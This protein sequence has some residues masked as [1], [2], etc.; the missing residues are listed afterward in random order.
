VIAADQLKDWLTI[1]FAILVGSAALCALLV[2]VLHPL[3]VRYALARPNARSSHKVPVPQGAGMAVMAAMLAAVV[4]T[5]WW[6]PSRAPLG[7]VV[8][9][10]AAA[11]FI[12]AVGAIDDLKPIPVLP[13]LFLQLIA[14]GTVVLALPYDVRIVP[15]LPGWLERTLLVLAMLWFV[16]LSNF[17]DGLDWMTIAEM[18]PTTTALA[19]FALMGLASS[20]TLP[21]IV[22]LAGALIG[23]APFNKPVARIFLGDVG[24]LPIGLIVAWGLVMLAGQHLTAALLLPLYY[25]A[26]A[27]LTL[28]MR[29]SRREKVWEAHRTHFYQRATDHGF[30]VLQVVTRVFVLNILLAILAT[31]SIR[32]AS[33]GTDALLLAIGALAVATVLLQFSQN[34]RT[35]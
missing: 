11:A 14:V 3:L 21:T 2:V 20:E 9:V 10:L 6:S 12:A 4:L 34:R 16:N 26:D 29:L 23:F 22:A 13:R 15:F 25:A 28:L 33:P 1:A 31:L 19:A 5:G 35:A 7:G 18:L 27:T 8:I 32:L 30:S 17:M 24:S